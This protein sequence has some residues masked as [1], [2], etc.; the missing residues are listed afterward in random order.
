MKAERRQIRVVVPDGALLDRLVA[1]PIP[2]PVLGEEHSLSMFRDVYFDTP[3]AELGRKQARVRIR[4]HADGTR[5]LLT[6]VR[7]GASGADTPPVRVHAE[8]SVDTAGDAM[9]LFQADSEPA[10]L[11]RALIDPVRIEP[12]FELETLRNIRTCRLAGGGALQ[13]TYD[14]LTV[15]RGD[16]SGTLWE[17]GVEADPDVAVEPLI[18]ML[19]GEP[20]CRIT[21]EGTDRRVREFLDEAEVA[22]LERD[23]RSGREV[24]VVPYRDGRIALRRERGGL[25]VPSGEG[26]GE[27]ACRRLLTRTT[28]SPVGR[29]RLLGT[30]RGG[31]GRPTLEVWLAERVAPSDGKELAWVPV[32]EALSSVGSAALRDA[33]TL[34]A[35][36]VIARSDLPETAVG[37]GVSGDEG[38]ADALALALPPTSAPEDAY[39]V[40]LAPDLLLNAELSRIG[41]D[42]RILVFAE[43]EE[44]PLLERVRFLSMFG[45]RQDDFFMSRVAGF[46]EELEGGGKRRTLD[47][48]TAH[49]Q[50]DLI[51]VRARQVAERANRLLLDRLIPALEERDIRI[52][53]WSELDAEERQFLHENYGTHAGAVL[54]PMAT[55]ASHPF[56]HIRNLRPAIGAVV[57]LPGSERTHFTAVQ[58]P[59]DL[60]RFLPLPDGLRFVPLEDVVLARLPELFSGLRVE[61]AHL[62]RVTRSAQTQ[63]EETMVSDV[64]QAVASDVAQRPFRAPVRLEVEAGMP[65]EIRRLILD[66]LRHE[67]PSDSSA[68]GPRDVYVVNGL[69]DLEAL[70]EIASVEH[71]DPSLTFAPMERARPFPEDVPVLDLVAE[72]DRLVHFPYDDFGNTAERFIREA[73]EDPR[74]LSLKVTLYRTDTDSE[75][76][77]ALN[78][79]RELGKDAVA[80]IEIKASFDEEQNIAWAKSL[81]AA[82][83]HVAFSPLKY[84][85]HA[86][87]AL[88]VRREGSQL[89][90]YS[91]IGTGNLNAAT[92]RSYTDVGL[93]TADPRIGEELQAVFNVLTGYSAEDEFEELLVSPFNMRRR[94]LRLIDREIE[95]ARAGRPAW[96]RGQ[97]NGLAD[98]RIIGKLYDASAA[99]VDVN[100]AVREIC[101]LRPGVPGLSENIRIVSLL[102]RLLQHAR[103]FEFGNDG[104]PDY[105]IGSADWR[106]RNLSRRVEVVTPVRHPPLKE[107]LAGMLDDVLNHPRVWELRPDGAHARDGEVVG[108]QEVPG[109]PVPD[110]GR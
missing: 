70:S 103:I 20:G 52:L 43:S 98:R 50:L 77:R 97:L 81:S 60:P 99:G 3:G 108:R 100:L 29:V 15:R 75:V 23:V 41:F 104:E 35:L 91:Y 89:R 54:T 9:E 78:R 71:P 4:H 7:G 67:A 85:V 64:L 21:L 59:G 11:L 80:L 107:R 24:A 25:R 86:K 72:Q 19:E 105:Y 14:T 2:L 83:V 69:I 61:S 62:F 106:P 30:N 13:V 12:A 45:A 42:E 73:A 110:I 93:L 37:S 16:L 79:A 95:N 44:T 96:L 82:G 101:A 66:E 46:K 6:D 49:E 40:E 55:D 65:S 90:H 92:V 10:R 58:L 28:G 76:V 87:A 8:A 51:G 27:G 39:D 94:I 22:A 47:G 18:R 88:V 68:L 5:V 32:A 31:P 34:A 84:K 38:G 26:S 63:I 57:R 17:V 33:R 53:R 109:R 1:E 74:V 102:G 48:L 56:P 36:E